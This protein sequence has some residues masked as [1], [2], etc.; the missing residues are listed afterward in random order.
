MNEW[1]DWDTYSSSG[2]SAII[3]ARGAL[4]LCEYPV[5]VQMAEKTG[6]FWRFAGMRGLSEQ[7]YRDEKNLPDIGFDA[8]GVKRYHVDG[9]TYEVRIGSTLT[10]ELTL[11]GKS[12]KSI[13]KKTPEGEVAAT[14]FAA[15]KKEFADF[16]KK[17]IEYIKS[18]YIRGYRRNNKPRKV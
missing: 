12:V 4:M 9:K 10:L 3:V 2:R 16:I 17:R 18:I 6:N 7:E 15:K 14:D 5:A 11:D 8:D 13:P 1:K